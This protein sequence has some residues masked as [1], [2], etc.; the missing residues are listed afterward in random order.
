MVFEHARTY[1]FRRPSFI[2]SY[3]Y[4][5]QNRLYEPHICNGYRYSGETTAIRR[6]AVRQADLPLGIMDE[7]G[8]AIE[9]P[10]K[11]LDTIVLWCLWDW[12]LYLRWVTIYFAQ[13]DKW[14]DRNIIVMTVFLLIIMN[15]ME[16][17][18]IHNRKE[19][20]H[21]HHISF[22]L[23]GILNLFIINSFKS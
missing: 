13:G 23:R 8:E 9:G 17:R 3:L 19:I 6:T 18:L 20:C 11:P 1:P 7:E 2:T 21:Y 10:L 4:I 22:N 14:Y 15:Q 16:F 5:S 12:L